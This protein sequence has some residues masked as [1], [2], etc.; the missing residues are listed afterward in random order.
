MNP[1]AK[2]SAVALALLGTL[3]S[4]AP[5]AAADPAKP[6]D[7]TEPAIVIDPAFYRHR[8][9][10]MSFE[11]G[12]YFGLAWFSS[13]LNLQDLS[14]VGPRNPHQEFNNAPSVGLRAG[15]FPLSFLGGE[16]EGGVIPS[17]TPD[18]QDAT[19]W[20]LR[21]AV[22]GQLPLAHVVPFAYLGYGLMSLVSAPMGHDTD[23]VT[24]FG[25]GLKL[26]IS[27]YVS[28]RVDARDNLMQK[29]RLLPGVQ[30]GDLVHNGEILGSALFTLGRTPWPE[31][32]GPLAPDFDK[33]GVPDDVDQCPGEPGLPPVG[34]PPPTD[35]DH[36][37][38]PDPSDKC[39]S[40]PEDG[41]TPDATDGCPTTPTPTPAPAPSEVP[42]APPVEPPPAVPPP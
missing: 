17:H 10:P 38:V 36:D 9:T 16:V 27:Q 8:P 3:T 24:Y 5:A 13:D 1:T 12:I 19:I 31:K 28:F 18:T 2:L 32:T 20:T 40:I 37:D 41:K 30:N 33:D 29:N 15:F 26:A 14:K 23:P 21:G 22:V 34:C 6:A 4:A 42:P 35:V 39:P 11:A 7:P 25:G